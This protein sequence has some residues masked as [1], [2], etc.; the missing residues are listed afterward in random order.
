MMYSVGWRVQADRPA[1]ASDAPISFRKLRRPFVRVLVLAPADRLA[2]ELALHQVL[3]F[4]RGRQFVEAA[5]VVAPA[6]AFEPGPHRR[7]I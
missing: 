4:G 1:S 6:L 5:P 3:E 2:R 7:E